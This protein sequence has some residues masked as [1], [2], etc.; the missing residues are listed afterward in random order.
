MKVH[1]RKIS[2]VWDEGYALDKHMLHST[3]TGYNEYGRPTFDNVR[4]E[5]GEAVYQL[6][7][8]KDWSQAIAL[9]QAVAAHILPKFPAIGLVIPMPASEARDRQPVDEVASELAKI[10]GVISFTNIIEKAHSATGK[11]LKDMDTKAEKDAEL[12]GRLSIKDSIGGNGQWNALLVDDLFE[13]GA[14]ME[15]ATKALRTYKKIAGI[16]VAALTWS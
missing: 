4:T 6:K 1:L 13:T 5:P 3:F 16:Y 2:G 8:R 15:A 7:Y 10:I 9:A 12:A 11:K 14:S